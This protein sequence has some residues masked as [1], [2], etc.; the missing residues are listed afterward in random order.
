[1]EE[2]LSCGDRWLRWQVATHLDEILNEMLAAGA[3]IA[4][5][6]YDQQG[7]VPAA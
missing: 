5:R 4:T 1:M 3:E 6:H 2:C 7:S